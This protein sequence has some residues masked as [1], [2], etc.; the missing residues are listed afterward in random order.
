[1]DAIPAFETE[2]LRLRGWRDKDFEPL[3]RMMADDEVMRFIGGEPIPGARWRS[4]SDTGRCAA[5]AS[6]WSSAR[7]T[8]PSL[9]ASVCGSR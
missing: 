1:M 2:R 7:P 6:G 3:C 4:S 8:A 5:M 9:G